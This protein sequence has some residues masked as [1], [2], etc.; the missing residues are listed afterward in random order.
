MKRRYPVYAMVIAVL[1]SA[2]ILLNGCTPESRHR[3][4]T[5]VFNDVPPLG[6]EKPAK[7]F[8]RKPRRSYEKP[9]QKHYVKRK[10]Y[11]PTFNTNWQAVF[12]TLPKDPT[13]GIDWAAALKEGTINPQAGIDSKTI[14]QPVLPL[15][16]V[17]EPAGLPQ[18]KAT[19]PHQPHTKWLA[20]SNCHPKIFTMQAGAD[21]INM[22]KIFSGQYCGSCHGK[23]AFAV[24]TGCP[25]C[26][27]ALA[28]SQ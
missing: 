4:A 24:A 15:D 5:I 22:E 27:L 13:G 23:V 20:C 18:F 19:F 26:H 8:I 17:L 6:K 9:A 21:P 14:E 16:V 25:R 1:C 12:D 11:K 28:A 3:L 10:K 7:P 2:V